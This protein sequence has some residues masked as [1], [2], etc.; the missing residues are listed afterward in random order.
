M[1]QRDLLKSSIDASK[2]MTQRTQE[3]L[4]A[5]VRELSAN[6]EEQVKQLQDAATDLVDRSRR[7]TDDLR[8]VIDSR[9]REQLTAFRVATKSDI[10]RIEK[11]L[12][13]LTGTRR[14]PT[15]AKKAP[16]KKAAAKKAPAKKAAAKKAPAKKAPA[17]KA[18]AK[19]APAKKAPAKK[20]AAKK[21]AGPATDAG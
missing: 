20:A 6:A 18:P 19:K 7:G 17:K 8:E 12:A 5:L 16:A 4:E 14:K 15:A 3:R 11:L 13:E 10:K 2:D 9:I 1:A 21:A